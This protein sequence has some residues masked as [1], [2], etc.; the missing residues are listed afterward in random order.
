MADFGQLRQAVV[1]VALNAV[2]AMGKTGTLT[3][4]TRA[5]GEGEVAAVISCGGVEARITRAGVSR[6]S[7]SPGARRGRLVRPDAGIPARMSAA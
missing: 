7:G 5:G 3:V 6:R 2:E 4:V 1:N